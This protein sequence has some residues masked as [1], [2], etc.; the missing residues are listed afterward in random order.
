MQNS[1]AG[2]GI[3]GLMAIGRTEGFLGQG[4]DHHAQSF[5]LFVM[6]PLGDST[7]TILAV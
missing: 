5:P 6:V 7:E 4:L 1:A 3:Y 2:P